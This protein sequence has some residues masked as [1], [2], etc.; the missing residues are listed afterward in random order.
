M[1]RSIRKNQVA[2]LLVAEFIMAGTTVVLSFDG[3]NDLAQFLKSMNIS[4]REILA[5][6]TE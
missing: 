1:V 4:E 3:I 6:C 2:N 5:A